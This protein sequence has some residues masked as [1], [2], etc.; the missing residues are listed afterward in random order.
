[1]VEIAAKDNAALQFVNVAVLVELALEQLFDAHDMIGSGWSIGIGDGTLGIDETAE[2]LVE[3][4]DPRIFDCWR[5]A[6]KSADAVWLGQE[7]HRRADNENLH[8][9][10][11]RRSQ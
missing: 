9:K 8:R 1:M 6:I 5:Q 4:F 11:N 10:C 2:L 7:R 3:G